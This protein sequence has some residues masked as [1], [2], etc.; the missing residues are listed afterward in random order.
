M[1]QSSSYFQEQA[2]EDSRISDDLQ[3]GNEDATALRSI[4]PPPVRLHSQARLPSQHEGSADV[5]LPQRETHSRR[6]LLYPRYP[7]PLRHP[8][9]PPS[10]TST[11]SGTTHSASLRPPDT[12]SSAPLL[13]KRYDCVEPVSLRLVGIGAFGST[14]LANDFLPAEKTR[15]IRRRHHPNSCLPSPHHADPAAGAS[16]APSPHVHVMLFLHLRGIHRADSQPTALLPSRSRRKQNS[17]N[18]THRPWFVQESS[19]RRST[20]RSDGEGKGEEGLTFPVRDGYSRRD[21]PEPDKGYG[22]SSSRWETVPAA[23]ET[24][25]TA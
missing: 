7:S 5:A 6:H 12:D 11:R 10:A 24:R 22:P 20:R 1:L 8:S 23:R 3:A 21:R 16:R 14:S 9:E 13:F 2:E 17:L 4:H 15:R 25:G 18:T 19:T